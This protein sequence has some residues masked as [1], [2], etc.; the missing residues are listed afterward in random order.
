M[1]EDYYTHEKEHIFIKE[2]KYGL[3]C[4]FLLLSE[5]IANKMYIRNKLTIYLF[6][7]ILSFY[8]LN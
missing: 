5:M 1:I 8:L 3:M 7:C 2:R 6:L 4:S